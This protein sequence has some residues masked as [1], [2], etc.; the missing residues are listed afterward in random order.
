MPRKLYIKLIY[1]RMIILLLILIFTLIFTLLTACS[2]GYG[3]EKHVLDIEFHKGTNGVDFDIIGL[4]PEIYE[5][6]AF[7]LAVNIFNKGA[8]DILPGQ[9]YVNINLERDYM[10][11]SDPGAKQCSDGTDTIRMLGES[12]QEQQLKGKSMANPPG[13]F[14]L[15][16][17]YVLTRPIDKQS[18]EHTSNIGVSACYQ[19]KTD[20]ITEVCIDP[21]FY[22][23]GVIEK[24][25]KVESKSFSGQGAPLAITKIETQMLSEGKNSVR[26]MFIITLQNS[27][28][29]EVIHKDMI[30]KV[31]TSSHLPSNAFNVI[32]LKSVEFLNGVYK[33]DRDDE[34]S[35]IE[36]TFSNKQKETKLKNRKAEIKCITKQPITADI[37]TISTQMKIVVDYGYTLSKS[38]QIKIKRFGTY[39]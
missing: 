38:Q 9:G 10:C 36:C 20:L 15:I 2:G 23:L 37:G 8:Y 32:H 28:N 34:N 1:T 22:E 18:F 31:C 7:K 17:Y 25:C 33:F 30:D 29:G 13:D 26:P 27:G 12:L 21:F 24:P 3:D 6:T 19:Y 39:G 35:N 5:D 16:E 4:M 11:L 14:E